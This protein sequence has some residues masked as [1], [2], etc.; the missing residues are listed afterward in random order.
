MV[1]FEPEVVAS[2]IEYVTTVIT[3]VNIQICAALFKRLAK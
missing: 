1:L 3:R 2:G